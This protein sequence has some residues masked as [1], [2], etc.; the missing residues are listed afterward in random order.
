MNDREAREHWAAS[1]EA[2]GAV[3]D[4]APKRA[5][6]FRQDMM[7]RYLTAMASHAS[8]EEAPAE[9]AVR[10]RTPPQ[11]PGPHTV[12]ERRVRDLMKRSVAGVSAD[13]PFLDVAR[14][15]SHLQVGAVPVVDETEH[16][17]GVI[18][19]SDLLARAATLAA[20]GE[21]PGALAR[22]LGL[23]PRARDT[24]QTAAELMSAPVHTA[25]PGTTVIEAARMAARSR[26]R[27][28]F[29]TDYKGRLVGVVS[30]GELLRA[31]VRDDAAI[32]AEIA[33][34]I[35]KG[36][37]GI[38]PGSLEIHVLD[39]AVTL[40]G[41]VDTVVIP[42]LTEEVA[43]IADVVEVVDQLTAT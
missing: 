32:R 13:T 28:L 20:P 4:L 41:K 34:R 29:V 1:A 37:F 40:R 30:R 9:P 2:R 12:A 22:V 10:K 17:I 24:G 6:G 5:E 15:L 33:T 43:K 19:E 14:Q 8:R 36:E 3:P 21:R 18:A 31:L 38:D 35:V 7:V 42:Q 39:G 25:H 26:I 27:Q 23:R 11:R 16:V